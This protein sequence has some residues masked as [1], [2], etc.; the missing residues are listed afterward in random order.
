MTEFETRVRDMRE[1]ARTAR[2]IEEEARMSREAWGRSMDAS[3]LACAEVMSLRTTVL[4]QQLEIRELQSA[5]HRR[6]MVITEMLATDHK[7][8]VQLTKALKLVKRLQTQMAELHYRDNRDPLR[9]LHSQ[10]YWRRLVAVPR[11]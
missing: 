10:S 1:H 5:D 4:A 9:V 6:Q 11:S 2:L 3:D 7:R 8:Q